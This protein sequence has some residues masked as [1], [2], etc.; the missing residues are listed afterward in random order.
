[1]PH[2]LAPS[3]EKS[4]AEFFAGIGLMRLGLENQ[5][6][7]ISYANDIDPEKHEMY[8]AHFH[9]EDR[10]FHL[11][12]VHFINTESVPTVA[13]ATASFPCNDLSLAGAR[14]GLSEMF[15]RKY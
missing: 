1:M 6:W 7:T 10:H 8:R 5:G 9:D 4:F 11:G 3:T 13:L 12:D 14:E 15:R 2:E